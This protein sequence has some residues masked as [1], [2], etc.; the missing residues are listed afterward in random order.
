M[1]DTLTNRLRGIYE[2][3]PNGEFGKR[4]FADFVPAISLEAASRIEELESL[5]TITSKVNGEK[6]KDIATE[7]F[8]H[9]YNY[10]GTN[11]DQGFD[12]WWEINE[13]RFGA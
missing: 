2:V 1:S 3:G 8:R 12:S 10:P 7:F 9:W 11:T 13:E 5:I 6:I 4:S